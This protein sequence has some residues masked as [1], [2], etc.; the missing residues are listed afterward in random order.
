MLS[1]D[2]RLE[3]AIFSIFCGNTASEVYDPV[4]PVVP[5]RI[6]FATRPGFTTPCKKGINLKTYAEKG[7]NFSLE[8]F[9][10]VPGA[11]VGEL[12][13]CHARCKFRQMRHERLYESFRCFK[14]TKRPR[15]S[16]RHPHVQAR[17][18]AFAFPM[19]HGFA[20]CGMRSFLAMDIHGRSHGVRFSHNLAIGRCA[21]VRF[22]PPRSWCPVERRCVPDSRT[23]TNRPDD[24]FR[25]RRNPKT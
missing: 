20:V 16:V 1:S 19:P 13:L 8:T 10:S 17:V 9:G 18:L 7:Q 22:G 15:H 3:C 21:H 14:P 25:V 6:R 5:T 12:P 23:G 4:K 24:H 11:S 2:N